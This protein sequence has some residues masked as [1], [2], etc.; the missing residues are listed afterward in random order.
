MNNI[1]VIRIK[2]SAYGGYG[3]GFHDG[4]VI[5]IRESLPGEL[6]EAELFQEKRDHAFGRLIK[7]IEVS[8]N[9]VKP[10]CS[11]FGSCGGCDYLHTDY[12]TE[13]NIK[14]D[15]IIDS[16]SR[17]A[18]LKSDDIP[19]IKIISD[20]RYNYRSHASVKCHSGINGFFMKGTSKIIQFPLN[21]CLLLSDELN[22]A[23][24]KN[25]KH[26]NDFKI[27]AGAD[28]S[29]KFSYNKD[30]IIRENE[31]NVIYD[32]E[33]D[34]FFQANRFLRSAMLDTVK[35]YSAPDQDNNFIDLACGVG[36]FTLHLASSAKSGTGIDIAEKNIKWAK[37]NA[38]LNNINNI[39]FKA[40]DASSIDS[41]KPVDAVF[42]D[43]PR[44]GI[45]KKTRK[46]IIA[47]KPSS[48]IYISCDPA[49][50]SRDMSDFIKAGFRL[51]KLLM[52]DMFPATYHIEII[53]KF[54]L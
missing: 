49:T 42:I 45:S 6:I 39:K 1:I 30:C 43:P 4:K 11:N 7:I 40:A 46:N 27:S 44:A 33:I 13:L 54:V 48:L 41:S 12:A 25:H 3:L 29:P 15:I 10:E 36:F 28:K 2:K 22:K 17:I 53:S 31:S 18:G 34:C 14:R 35:D 24:S 16:L 26:V 37:H 50:F 32:R 8:K 9:R 21:G 47:L 38:K 20:R 19:N 52:I 51:D 5:F 23:L